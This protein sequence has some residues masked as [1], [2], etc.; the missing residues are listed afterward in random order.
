MCYH[1]MLID[2]S[3]FNLA[4]ELHLTLP[5]LI[6]QIWAAARCHTPPP[7]AIQL[8]LLGLERGM[9]HVHAADLPFVVFTT[10][11]P[12]SVQYNVGRTDSNAQSF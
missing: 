9:D 6:T 2:S 4:H 3:Y 8:H 1:F 7:L 10:R 11:F 5:R 12:H